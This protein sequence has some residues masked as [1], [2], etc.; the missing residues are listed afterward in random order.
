MFNRRLNASAVSTASPVLNEPC[1]NSPTMSGRATTTM[2]TDDGKIT[3]VIKRMPWESCARKPA[4]SSRLTA[5]ANSGVTV[6][7]SDTANSPYGN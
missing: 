6:V 5:D 7:I 4:M 2:P 1:T 3:N